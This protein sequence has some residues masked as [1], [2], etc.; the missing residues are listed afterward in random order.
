MILLFFIF[1]FGTA[2]ILLIKN[3]KK[4]GFSLRY[5]T[6]RGFEIV[7]IIKGILLVSAFILVVSATKENIGDKMYSFDDLKP[8]YS[9]TFH[10]N[11]HS[12]Y[13][14]T[15]IPAGEYEFCSWTSTD[16]TDNGYIVYTSSLNSEEHSWDEIRENWKCWGAVGGSSRADRRDLTV[17]EGE[18]VYIIDNTDYWMFSEYKSVI[19]IT[20]K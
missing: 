9:K 10:L 7:T 1:I 6:R 12:E 11:K 13:V 16:I 15:Q 20:G 5:V 3:A 18:Y 4:N 8:K 14:R 19:T 17:K 2:G